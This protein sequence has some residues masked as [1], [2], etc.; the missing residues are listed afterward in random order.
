MRGHGHTSDAMLET[1]VGPLPGHPGQCYRRWMCGTG[2]DGLTDPG[3]MSTSL[4]SCIFQL[5]SIAR[6]IAQTS[7]YAFKDIYSL[8]RSVALT[9]V[10]KVSERSDSDKSTLLTQQRR[11]SEQLYSKH[12]STAPGYHVHYWSLECVPGWPITYLL[13][14]L[15]V[16]Q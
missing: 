12:F 1:S 10:L 8:S 16:L 7:K 2:W 6:S 13:C 3:K 15:R 14:Q 5:W 4:L 11:T 9:E